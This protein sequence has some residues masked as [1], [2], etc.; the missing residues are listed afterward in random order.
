[1]KKTKEI[2]A[3]KIYGANDAKTV[4]DFLEK[5]VPE[6]KEFRNERTFLNFIARVLEPMLRREARNS[7]GLS[8]EFWRN[9]AI[10]MDISNQFNKERNILW[11]IKLID[12]TCEAPVSEEE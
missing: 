3:N 10:S 5:N 2:F 8:K 4:L 6:K 9:R 1:M 11:C 7:S 12:G